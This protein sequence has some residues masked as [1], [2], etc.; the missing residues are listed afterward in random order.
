[1]LRESAR[2]VPILLGRGARRVSQAIR[3]HGSD[4]NMK[5]PTELSAKFIAYR[6]LRNAQTR[7]YHHDQLERDR[8]E[9]EVNARNKKDR[10]LSH[11]DR[12]GEEA[13]D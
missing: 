4:P 2:H 3:K 7:D 12:T 6:E 8:I 1:M 9:D 10:M 11:F 5:R 13:D